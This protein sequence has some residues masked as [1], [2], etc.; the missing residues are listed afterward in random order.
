MQRFSMGVLQLIGVP[1]MVCRRAAR[2]WRMVIKNCWK[3]L[4]GSL[5][6]F[7]GQR[8]VVM[9]CLFIEVSA[10][11]GWGTDNQTVARRTWKS[12]KAGSNITRGRDRRVVHEGQ[13][14]VRRK[15]LEIAELTI[16]KSL[17]STGLVFSSFGENWINLD[18]ASLDG[19]R[20]YDP[21]KAFWSVGGT[22]STST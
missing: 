20:T 5:L 18:Q 10:S 4:P 11:R 6:L 16:I 7:F 8:S 2:I 1:Q 21:V 19:N 13:C 3:K 22:Y 15:T 9:N 12:L 14:A 17:F